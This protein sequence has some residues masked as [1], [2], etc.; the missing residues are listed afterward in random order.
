[1]R[2]RGVVRILVAMVNPK[3]L[4]AQVDDIEPFLVVACAVKLKLFTF[5][6]RHEP[7]EFVADPVFSQFFLEEE[8]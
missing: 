1:M 3:A 4:E 7:A 8:G 5:V 2:S 6:F